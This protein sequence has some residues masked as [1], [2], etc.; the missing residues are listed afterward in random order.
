MPSQT[1]QAIIGTALT[2]KDFRKALLG[3]SRRRVLQAFPLSGDEIEALMAIRADSLEQFAGELD[4]W[5]VSS[6][7]NREPAPLPRVRA[8]NSRTPVFAL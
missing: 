1:L 4:R 3:S 5:I 8:W 7:R 2:D 6:E